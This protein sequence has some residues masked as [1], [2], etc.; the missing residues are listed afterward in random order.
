MTGLAEASSTPDTLPHFPP[1][2][3]TPTR[4]ATAQRT[5]LA[6][7]LCPATIEGP[8][9]VLALPLGAL[10]RSGHERRPAR[11]GGHRPGRSPGQPP[12]AAARL[13]PVAPAG[14]AEARP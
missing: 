1:T 12:T 8:A 7:R 14:G 3:E 11:P 9:G 5:V 6:S 4:R 10:L 13:R 2:F